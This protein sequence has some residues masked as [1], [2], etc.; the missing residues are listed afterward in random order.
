[1]PFQFPPLSDPRRFPLLTA[2]GDFP[3][4]TLMACDE[5]FFSAASNTQAVGHIVKQP[6]AD[7]H[8]Y[9]D[10]RWPSPSHWIEFPL[11]S[12]FGTIACGILVVRSS[13][14]SNEPAPLSWAALNHPLSKILPGMNADSAAQSVLRLFEAQRSS[15]E[16]VPGP[17]VETPAHV[18]GYCLFAKEPHEPA[19][20]VASYTDLLNPDGVPI[21]RFRIADVQRDRVQLC[22]SVLHALFCLNAA[23]IAGMDFLSY[24]QLDQFKP[25]LLDGSR[26]T[27]RWFAF[28]PCR[29]LR[30]RPAVRNLPLP[31][32]KD[33]IM[34]FDDHQQISDVRRRE[35]NT[36]M[37]AFARDARPR[38]PGF[39]GRDTNSCLA[40]FVNRAN[41][42]AIYV[43]PEQ[44]VEEFDHTECGEVRVADL[45]LPFHNVF[46][47]FKPPH[48]IF[49]GEGAQVDGCYVA[50]QGDEY[51][52]TVTSR[53]NEVDYE[54]SLSVAC[55]D[56]FFSLHLP[57]HD[58]EI[59]INDAVRLGI[60]AFLKDNEPPEN[61]LSTMI[62]LPNGTS[63][64]FE[65]VRAKSRKHRITIFRSQEASFRA[66]LNIIVNAACFISFRPSDITEGWEGNPSAD[67]LA[68]ATSTSDSRGARDR[69]A[70]A[71]QKIANGDFTRVKICGANLFARHNVA[72]AGGDG[73]SP[74]T[75][76]RRGHWRRQKHGVGLISVI[77]RWIRPTIVNPDHGPLVETRIYE[78]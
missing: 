43:L 62:E 56:P 77:L 30:S 31:E 15:D 67:V 22:R 71:L 11:P 66:C 55:V 10:V 14:P 13:I 76:W 54:R 61:N 42:A 68:A 8:S 50:K 33:G 24:G 72:L 17:Q 41:G 36:H 73:K 59:S 19:E 48:P 64:F 52:F 51:L 39:H 20:F 63:S 1:M 45:A 65:D 23:R 6:S 3:C 38:E 46:L 47:S 40:A 74:R 60:E 34:S 12:H 57:A 35:L 49:L 2:L 9:G 78:V 69:K 58:S 75:H 37:L 32:L 21:P 16:N 5:L 4:T 25:T 18:H 53:L 27:P 28:P 29:A 26:V 70:G 44:L 7:W